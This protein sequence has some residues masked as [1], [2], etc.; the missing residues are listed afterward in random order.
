MLPLLQ[1]KNQ[2]SQIFN[3]IKRSCRPDTLFLNMWI[4]TIPE[5]LL[6]FWGL[7]PFLLDKY[8]SSTAFFTEVSIIC[9]FQWIYHLLFNSCCITCNWFDRHAFSLF[10]VSGTSLSVNEQE[11][12]FQTVEYQLEFVMIVNSVWHAN[13]SSSL[14]TPGCIH[15]ISC[16]E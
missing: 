11:F 9:G 5:G 13:V 16:I 4:V 6:E 3:F 12:W 8:F 10:Y 1:I 15:M 2:K 7:P 14:Y